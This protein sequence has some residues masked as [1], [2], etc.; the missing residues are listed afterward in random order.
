M[1]KAENEQTEKY[2][3]FGET[4]E[5]SR[6]LQKCP[7]TFLGSFWEIAEMKVFM[8][9]YAVLYLRMTYFSSHRAVFNFTPHVYPGTLL[10]SAKY[11]G[12]SPHSS[13]QPPHRPRRHGGVVTTYTTSPNAVVGD[14]SAR[15]R[16]RGL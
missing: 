5:N 15:Y 13:Q 10:Y 12:I 9:V 4:L 2:E 11:T 6:R 3:G 8:T 16:N 1:I 14:I 7:G